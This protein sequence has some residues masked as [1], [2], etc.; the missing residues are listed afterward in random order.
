VENQ[1]VES[2]G[3]QPVLLLVQYKEQGKLKALYANRHVR[4]SFVP[5]IGMQFLR[6]GTNSMWVTDHGEVTP[7][8]VESVIYDFDDGDDVKKGEP[9]RGRTGLIVC[10]FTVSKRMTSAFWGER[11]ESPEEIKGTFYTDYLLPND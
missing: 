6:S 5:T 7:P 1:K 9:A 3:K 8:K 11:F 4:L 10:V 2:D